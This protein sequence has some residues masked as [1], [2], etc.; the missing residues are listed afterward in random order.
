MNVSVQMARN[1]GSRVRVNRKVAPT[2]ADDNQKGDDVQVQATEFGIP[3]YDDLVWDVSLVCDRIGSSMQHGLKGKLQLGDYLDAR[4]RS[5]IR[6]YRRDYAIKNIAFIGRRR[7][8]KAKNGVIEICRAGLE[9]LRA[10]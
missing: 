3:G 7:K 6:R 5:K 1:I 10:L 9:T 4:A 8:V 2:A